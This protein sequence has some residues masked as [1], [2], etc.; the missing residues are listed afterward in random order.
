MPGLFWL[1]LV[2]RELS[3]NIDTKSAST[4]KVISPRLSFTYNKA[5]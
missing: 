4:L 2:L 1:K 3:C 5:V